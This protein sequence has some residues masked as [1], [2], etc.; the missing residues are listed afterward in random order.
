MQHSQALQSAVLFMLIQLLEALDM[1]CSHASV[2]LRDAT[3]C[4]T[5]HNHHAGQL[6]TTHIFLHTIAAPCPGFCAT[7]FAHV[8]QAN[9][10]LLTPTCPIATVLQLSCSDFDEMEQLF[11]QQ[12][13]PNLDMA[14]LEAMCTEFKNDYNQRHFVRNETFKKAAEGITGETRKIFIEFLERSCTAEF[15]GFLLYK[16]RRGEPPTVVNIVVETVFFQAAAVQFQAAAVQVLNLQAWLSLSHNHPDS[17][18]VD[19]H[20]TP[21][22]MLRNLLLTMLTTRPIPSLSCRSLGAA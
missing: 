7:Y 3:P 20:C 16:V 4:C 21:S 8:L 18:H 2:M 11:S 13:N 12:I 9:Q 14:E 19:T 15:S 1:L 17:C 10:P 22:H 6:P 5:C